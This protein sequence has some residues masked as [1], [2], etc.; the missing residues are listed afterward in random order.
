MPLYRCTV[1]PGATSEEQRAAIAKEVVRVH[2]EVTGAPA[3]FV[4]A[5]FAEDDAALPEG[6]RAFVIGSI[7]AGRDDPQKA[8]I[9]SELSHFIA[10]TLRCREDEVGVVTVDVPARWI[11]EG[12]AIMPEPGEEAE[13]LAKHGPAAS[14]S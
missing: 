14:T 3:T 2:C 4:H 12:G 10:N 11:M 1:K 7:R 8:R 6:K 5:F 9:V 13:W